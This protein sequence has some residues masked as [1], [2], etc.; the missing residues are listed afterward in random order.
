MDAYCNRNGYPI[1]SVRF[2][3]EGE[4]IKDSDTPESLKMED[5]D[6]IDAMIEQHGGC[7]IQNLNNFFF[8]QCL[9]F[10]IFFID[11]SFLKIFIMEK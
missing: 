5:N 4:S 3:Y 9:E 2:I 1:T 7:F 11:N 6:E 8:G 10:F